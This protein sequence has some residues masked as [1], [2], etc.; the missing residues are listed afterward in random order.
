MN[1]I[2]ACLLVLLFVI[3]DYPTWLAYT[4]CRNAGKSE[5]VCKKYVGRYFR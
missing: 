1:R 4:E 2:L 3:R 5:H